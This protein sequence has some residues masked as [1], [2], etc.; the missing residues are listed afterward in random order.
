MSQF[1]WKQCLI[2]FVLSCVFVIV[3]ISYPYRQISV[4]SDSAVI[5]KQELDSLQQGSV[6]CVAKATK[7]TADSNDL[8]CDEYIINYKLFNL[9]NITNLRVNVIADNK[10]YAGGNCLGFNIL[11]KGVVVV[12]SNFILTEHGAVNPMTSSGLKVGDIITHI[13]GLE[14]C[15][16]SDVNEYLDKYVGG[17]TKLTVTRQGKVVYVDIEPAFD[18]QTQTYKLGLWLKSDASGV[19]TL[20]YVDTTTGRYGSL[21]HA[22]TNSS[23]QV[24]DVTGG[25]I[26]ET[27]VIGVN[28]GQSGRPGELLGAFN[29]TNP[30]GS[31]DKNT[32][33]GVFGDVDDGNT[34]MKDKTEIGVGGRL[35]VKPGKAQIL[36]T[37][38]GFNIEAF[39]VEI[40][41]TNFQSSAQEKSMVIRV[42]DK[43]LLDVTGGI[44][45]G[46]SG[47][48]IIQDGKLVGA[49]THV[50][51]NDPTKGFGIYIDWM[52]GN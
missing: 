38:D 47:S 33:F 1:K 10:I 29:T 50:F 4:L 39:D 37:I 2:F 41:K 46:M 26:Y 8:D 9:F 36:S 25:N 32:N 30:Q 21:G 34:L 35:T 31:V 42:I 7:L 19:G 3:A 13:D 23:N 44:V 17:T 11:S 27:N 15:D 20:T 5:T 49:V 28:K 16:V 18:V 52:L 48:P 51:V 22:I 14:I 45:Q 43:R 6:F 12:G 40:I 24:F